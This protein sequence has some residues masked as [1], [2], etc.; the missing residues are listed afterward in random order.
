[1]AMAFGRSPS[2]GTCAVTARVAGSKTWTMFGIEQETKARGGEPA[3][4]MSAGVSSVL[5]VATTFLAV[6]ST[7]LTESEMWLTTHTSL[8]VRHPTETGS[9]PTGTLPADVGIPVVTS[10]SSKR[11]SGRLQTARRLPSGLNEIG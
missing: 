11:L 9:K 2:I 8:L 3:N 4:T 7:M 1:M 6:G 5:S 10:K